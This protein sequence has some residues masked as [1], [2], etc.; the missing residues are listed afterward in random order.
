MKEKLQ[1]ELL[2]VTVSETKLS[3]SFSLNDHTGSYATVLTERESS[4]ATVMRE[5]ENRLNTDK[6]TS[7]RNNISLQ[8]TVTTAAAAKEA[9]E[10]EDVIIRVILSQLIDTAVSTFNLAFLTVMKAAAAS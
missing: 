7:R 9:E 1:I 4:V 6:L 3:L 5:A 2:R 10:G 8:G